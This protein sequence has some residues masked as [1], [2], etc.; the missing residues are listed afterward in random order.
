[1]S[2]NADQRLALSEVSVAIDT[3]IAEVDPGGEAVNKNRSLYLI[4]RD[5]LADYVRRCFRKAVHQAAKTMPT[6]EVTLR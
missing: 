3:A 5:D 1:M 2:Y 4:S 6:A